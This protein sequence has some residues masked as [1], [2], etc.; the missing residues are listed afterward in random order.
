MTFYR[1][2]ADLLLGLA[3]IAVLLVFQTGL[4]I[5]RARGISMS[6]GA[7]AIAIGLYLLYVAAVLIA[8]YYFKEKTFLFRWLSNACGRLAKTESELAPVAAGA[9][10]ALAGFA[11]IAAGFV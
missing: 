2:P 7:G 5:A 10:A 6:E 11:T 1:S 9:V 3:V 4:I 8:S